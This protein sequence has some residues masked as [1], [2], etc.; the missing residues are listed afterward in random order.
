V[1]KVFGHSLEELSG[2]DELA[3]AIFSGIVMRLTNELLDN[4]L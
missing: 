2:Q 4:G 3:E 1:S